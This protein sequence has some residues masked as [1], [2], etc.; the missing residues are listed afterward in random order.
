MTIK[1]LEKIMEAAQAA[2][3]MSDEDL[4][5]EIDR[6]AGRRDFGERF[7][8]LCREQNRRRDEAEAQEIAGLMKELRHVFSIFQR[9]SQDPS[10]GRRKKFYFQKEHAHWN[11]I[12]LEGIEA[13]VACNYVQ[14]AGIFKGL[15]GQLP[16]YLK[17]IIEQD[18]RFLSAFERVRRKG[19]RISAL[20]AAEK[21][22]KEA[23]VYLSEG[24]MEEALIQLKHAAEILRQ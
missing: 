1:N 23:M 24:R 20:N 2:R 17:Q 13:L 19:K 8:G 21:A 14:A 6:L 3:S 4:A 11:R 15:L 9:Q 5:R 10:G 22:Y 16:D 7:D 12:R 18:E